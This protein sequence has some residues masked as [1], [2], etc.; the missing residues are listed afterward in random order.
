MKVIYFKAGDY[1]FFVYKGN[2]SLIYISRCLH[3][4]IRKKMSFRMLFYSRSVTERRRIDTTVYPSYLDENGEIDPNS[5]IY[6]YPLAKNYF[7]Y[8]I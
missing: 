1:D 3:R 7:I 6:E 5:I 4:G 8:D 2:P